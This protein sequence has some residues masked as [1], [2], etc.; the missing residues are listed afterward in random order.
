VCKVLV[1]KMDWRG[2]ILVAVLGIC[3]G[4]VSGFVENPPE[5]SIIGHKYY[6][7]PLVWRIVRMF[8]GEEYLYLELFIDCLIWIAIVSVIAMF[9]W[10]S[11]RWMSR[12][13][14]RISE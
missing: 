9:A 7:H 14:A 13:N 6:G 8:F 1:V 2:L 10:E 12:K 5:A 11:S 3:I 4:L